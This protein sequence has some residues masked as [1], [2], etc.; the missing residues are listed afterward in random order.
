MNGPVHSLPPRLVR[1]TVASSASCPACSLGARSGAAARHSKSLNAVTKVRGSEAEAFRVRLNF[2]QAGTRPHNWRETAVWKEGEAE[3]ARGAGVV[4][5]LPVLVATALPQSEPTLHICT[6]GLAR[7]GA[8]SGGRG[9]R[10]PGYRGRWWR[11]AALATVVRLR[12]HGAE[13]GGADLPRNCAAELA[14]PLQLLAVVA[15]AAEVAI[16]VG[17]AEGQ[18]DDGDEDPVQIEFEQ[19]DQGQQRPAASGEGRG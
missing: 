2:A 14:H 6:G 15:A 4:L 8:G 11:A 13:H 10:R 7:L 3:T 9:V 17:A 18:G 16:E 1:K 5:R 19:G 12:E